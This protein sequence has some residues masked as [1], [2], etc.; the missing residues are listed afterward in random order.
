ML[1]ATAVAGAFV[2]TSSAGTPKAN[3]QSLAWGPCADEAEGW[4]CASLTVPVDYS[5]PDGASMDL[6][7]TRLP[8]SDPVRK[9]GPL[10]LNFG[11]PGGPAVVTSHEMGK[12]IFSDEIRA[13]FD[14]VGFDPRG[15][16]E[17][18]GIDCKVDLAAY[19]AIDTSPDTAAE[20]QA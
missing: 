6:A 19:Y 4:Q 13:R 3:A 8:A 15:V 14:L 16:G 17:S 11:G 2:S 18:A 12:V 7:L 5:H 20:R 1:F 9:I 10:V